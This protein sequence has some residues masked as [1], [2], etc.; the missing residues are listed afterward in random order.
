VD[1]PLMDPPAIDGESIDNLL[2]ILKR[3]EYRYRYWAKREL[4]DK[5][6]EAVR[7]ALDRWVAALERDDPRFRHHQVE[8]IWMYRNID[9]V[10]TELLREVLACEEHH[11][12]AAATR[13]L[14]YWYP[15]LPDAI[16]VLRRSANDGN[17]LVRLEAVI[18]TSYIGTRAALD[19]LMEAMALL[20]EVGLL[21]VSASP[22]D[23]FE[24]MGLARLR[25][26]VTSDF[27]E[28]K[29]LV[30]AADVAALPRTVCSGYPIKLLNNLALG[31]PTVA[32][33]GS[34]LPLP[35]VVPVPNHDAPAM[36]AAIQG[37][38]ADGQVRRRMG[39]E[40]RE[41]VW[42]HASWDA[43][44]ADLEAVYESVLTGQQG[45]SRQLEPIH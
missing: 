20:P 35:G 17:G 42:A 6:P 5:D 8:A 9:A 34:A 12:R 33:A 25:T 29:A 21:L 2:E 7:Q 13:Q 44:A 22:L 15:H 43:R 23:A 37:L 18:A 41:H 1:R 28:V 39:E 32:A 19:V 45:T 11:A 40:A 38:L 27:A 3:R 24:G 14:R 36:A 26:V 10:N 4:R 31:V 16:E 30:A